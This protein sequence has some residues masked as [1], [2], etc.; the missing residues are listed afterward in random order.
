MGIE[1]DGTACAL[2][3][4]ACRTVDSARSSVSDRYDGHPL[5]GHPRHSS[6]RTPSNYFVGLVQGIAW[7]LVHSNGF[8]QLHIAVGITLWILS[9]LL[10]VWAVRLR[11]RGRIVAAVLAW[12]GLTGAGFNG[13]SFLNE[14]GMNISSFLMS[15]G[16]ALAAFCYV[17]IWGRP[18]TSRDPDTSRDPHTSRDPDTSRDQ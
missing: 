18:H 2:S 6:G 10:I 12:F 14:G 1:Y 7:A 13:G 4:H 8:L 15:V 17:W 5:G 16:M 9:I 11:G 3:A